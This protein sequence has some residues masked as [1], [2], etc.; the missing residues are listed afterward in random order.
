VATF[1]GLVISNLVLNP[2]GE[3]LTEE[4]KKDQMKSEMCIETIDLIIEGANIIELQERINSYLDP[5]ERL[6]S[7]NLEGAAEAI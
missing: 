2:L 5:S 1:Y 6:N 7:L 3:W 4:T